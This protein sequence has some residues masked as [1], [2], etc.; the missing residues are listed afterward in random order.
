MSDA[1]P[2]R[3]PLLGYIVVDSDSDEI[4]GTVQAHSMPWALR[5]ARKKHPRRR[6][7]VL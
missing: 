6:V 4:L 1:G 2:E 3:A 5:T 7:R